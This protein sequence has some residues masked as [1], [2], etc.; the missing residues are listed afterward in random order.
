MTNIERLH[1]V[2]FFLAKGFIPPRGLGKTYYLCHSV[3]G[4]LT[5][6]KNHT[7]AVF[8]DNMRLVEHFQATLEKV[9]PEYDL[10]VS[11]MDRASRRI[12]FED[13]T[14]NIK[15]FTRDSLQRMHPLDGG[16]KPE[17]YPIIDFIDTYP[18]DHPFGGHMTMG[19]LYIH[20]R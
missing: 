2:H 16:C 5:I 18:L 4:Q 1:D 10:T 12:F 17:Q 9:L 20:T 13:N 15:Y 6:L 19:D 14:N 11:K 7:V 3:C 8:C